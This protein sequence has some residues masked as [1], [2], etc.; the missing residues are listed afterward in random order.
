MKTIVSPH[1]HLRKTKSIFIIFLDELVDMHHTRPKSATIFV[2]KVRSWLLDTKRFEIQTLFIYC[3]ILYD[4][5]EYNSQRI[6]CAVVNNFMFERLYILT[7][8]QL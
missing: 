7:I 1:S 8:G 3:R 6:R 2:Q 5:A 4:F